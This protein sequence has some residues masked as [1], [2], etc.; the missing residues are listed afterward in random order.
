MVVF[1][2]QVMLWGERARGTWNRSLS[3]LGLSLDFLFHSLLFP[4]LSFLSSC[5]SQIHIQRCFQHNTATARANYNCTCFLQH[6]IHFLLAWI[7]QVDLW[8]V[9]RINMIV[10]PTLPPSLSFHSGEIFFFLLGSIFIPCPLN[11]YLNLQYWWTLFQTQDSLAGTTAQFSTGGC[12]FLRFLRGQRQW[13][14]EANVG[15]KMTWP[16][17]FLSLFF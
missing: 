6:D 17:D 11:S 8:E 9:K 5:L 13:D 15:R 16:T 2:W 10:L 14:A 12:K 3:S 7:V 4:A 1:T